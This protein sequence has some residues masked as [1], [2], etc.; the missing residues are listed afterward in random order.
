MADLELF[1]GS[2]ALPPMSEVAHALIR[3]LNSE[4]TSVQEVSQIIEKD[5]ALCAQILRLANSAQFGLPRGIGRM[6]EAV[7]LVGMSRVRSLALGACLAGSFP[8]LHGLDRDTFWH[9]SMACAGYAQ[10]LAFGVGM[11]V[12]VAW[13]SGMM[14]RLGE[15]LIGQVDPAA[16]QTIEKLPMLPGDRWRREQQLL[17]FSEG[18]IVSELARRWNF[19]MQIVQGLQR[20][21]DPLLEQAFSRLGA[22]LHLAFHLSESTQSSTEARLEALPVEVIDSLRLDLDW[23][24]QT[25]PDSSAFL[26]VSLR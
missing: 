17:G 1:I 3:S 26:D 9:S 24:R 25:F 18:H 5:P 15:V 20:A 8:C 21:S 23:M 13:L 6:E 4:N 22:V 11:D 2:V 10:W 14:L 12:Q 16:L 7:A 19:P